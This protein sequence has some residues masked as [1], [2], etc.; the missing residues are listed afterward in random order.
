MNNTYKIFY[1]STYIG[2]IGTNIL[3]KMSNSLSSPQM[4]IYNSSLIGSLKL[5]NPGLMLISYPEE[6]IRSYLLRNIYDCNGLLNYDADR[7]YLI[8]DHRKTNAI[9]KTLVFMIKNIPLKRSRYTFVFCESQNLTLSIITFLLRIF[10]RIN[11]I[12]FV[13][14]IPERLTYKKSI[15]LKKRIYYN[16][17]F[18]FMKR[19]QGYIFVSDAMHNVLPKRKYIT[20]KGQINYDFNLERTISSNRK[21]VLYSG[22]LTEE[23]GL[24]T[25]LESFIQLDIT[26]YELHIYG[27][28]SLVELVSSY[29]AKYDNIIFFGFKDVETI[30][31]A[32]VNADLLINPRPKSQPFVKYSFPSKMLE[33]LASQ[34]PILTT[35]IYGIDEF[36]DFLTIYDDESIT[37]LKNAINKI[38]DYNQKDL[39]AEKAINGRK[40]IA[41]NYSIDAVSKII[42]NFI[43]IMS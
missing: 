18:F 26:K 2:D 33:Y 10:R 12:K 14:D 37:G 36:A 11:V 9:I 24:P 16:L 3:K 30:R 28:G 6:K 7:Q 31:T 17:I 20:I 34:T 29:S 5:F 15:G 23:N 4:E 25:L 8:I 1:L 42:E 22:S 19:S 13:T 43:G 35:R 27:K 40:Y 32:Q 39:L 38:F 21:I 41:E